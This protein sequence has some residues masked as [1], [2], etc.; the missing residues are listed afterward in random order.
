MSPRNSNTEYSIAYLI[1]DAEVLYVKKF[2]DVSVIWFEY[3][4]VMP[5]NMPIPHLY[6]QNINIY[7]AIIIH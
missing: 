2:Y 6:I 5:R 1:F 7:R 4:I 3:L